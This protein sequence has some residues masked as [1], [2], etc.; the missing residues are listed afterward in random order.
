MVAIGGVDVEP[1]AEVHAIRDIARDGRV[2]HGQ[3]SAVGVDGPAVAAIVVV[4]R[5]AGDGE[6]G[7]VGRAEAVVD[8]A[9]VASGIPLGQAEA[10]DPHRLVGRR[11]V[12]DREDPTA[13]VAGHGEGLGPRPLNVERIGDLD[14]AAGEGDSPGCAGSE[15]DRVPAGGG[16]GLLDRVAQAP[17]A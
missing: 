3:R 6:L 14:V 7:R 10:A 11:D 9:A 15:G 16:V 8:S 12:A 4:Q 17:G 1:A 2:R 13:A 5:R